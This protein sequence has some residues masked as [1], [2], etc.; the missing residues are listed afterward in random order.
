M[1]VDEFNWD[2]SFGFLFESVISWS[3]CLILVPL[4]SSSFDSF[5][6]VVYGTSSNLD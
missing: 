1:V 4:D 5:W 6:E 2:V 3:V